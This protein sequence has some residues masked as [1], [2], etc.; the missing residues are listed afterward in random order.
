M[1]AAEARTFLAGK[2]AGK[3]VLSAKWS[4]PDAIRFSGGVR[5]C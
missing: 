3:V 2:I 1:K 4:E 5:C